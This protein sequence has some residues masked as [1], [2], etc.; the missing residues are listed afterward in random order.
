MDFCML[1]ADL[2]QAAAGNCNDKEDLIASVHQHGKTPLG[3]QVD[4]RILAK[5]QKTDGKD[6]AEVCKDLLTLLTS[7]HPERYNILDAS[8][9]DY[10]VQKRKEL[11]QLEKTVE[12]LELIEKFKELK[13]LKED[14]GVLD[15]D[16][17]RYYMLTGRSL[18]LISPYDPYFE[19]FDT[20]ENDD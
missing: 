15:A 12:R 7:G 16:M 19:Q 4:L 10:L 14:D 5:M 13:K 1:I 20:D 8:S 6:F 3:E 2:Q 18:G 11:A 9:H 17:E